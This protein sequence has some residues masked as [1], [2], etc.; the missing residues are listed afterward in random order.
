RDGLIAV[1]SHDRVIGSNSP[2]QEMLHGAPYR[3]RPLVELFP[4][5]QASDA[6]LLLHS[7]T[8]QEVERSHIDAGLTHT[9]RFRSQPTRGVTLLLISDVTAERARRQ[10]RQQAAKLQLVGELAR[11]VANDFNNLLCG[12][13]GHA[14]LLPRLPPGAAEMADSIESITESAGRGI[15]LAGHLMELSRPSSGTVPARMVGD[16]VASAVDV[17]RGTLPTGWNVETDIKDLPATALTGM[18][19]EQLV[20]N[21]GQIVAESS[22][23]AD[24][25]SVVVGPPGSH[26]LLELADS[27]CGGI[28]LSR[29]GVGG[30]EVA[31]AP[32]ASSEETGL[33]LSV[34]RSILDGAGGELHQLASPDGYP[35]FRIALP[36]ATALDATEEQV[37]LPFDIDRYVAH[38][39]VLIAGRK[40]RHLSLVQRLKNLEVDVALV[41]TIADILDATSQDARLD[42]VIID[43][44]LLGSHEEGTLK[45]L[46]KLSPAS[47]I[48]V[49]RHERPRIGHHELPG[50]V[51]VQ[52]N[53]SADRILM[54]MVEARSLA[55]ARSHDAK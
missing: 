47:G 13:A 23:G 30:T 19:I 33:I 46:A 39:S 25:I 50:V 7:D 26:P 54:A 29:S 15:A 14:A 21:L 2:A 52:E 24:V 31:G 28:M 1:D 55:A 9:L 51:C 35:I 37:E 38:W 4:S 20:L 45:A 48:V 27:F 34:I 22:G 36:V 42:V 12:I 3:K 49:L 16:H 44:P 5:L 17:L 8:P 40:H 53:A 41:D 32:S 6:D 10:H 11:A 18:Q 43:W